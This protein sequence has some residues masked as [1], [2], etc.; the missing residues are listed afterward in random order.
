MLYCFFPQLF[1][2][3][4]S[5]SFFSTQVLAYSPAIQL[6]TL[7]SKSFLKKYKVTETQA[8]SDST[9][10]TFVILKLHKK[11][12]KNPDKNK[13]SKQ[14]KIESTPG[15]IFLRHFCYIYFILLNPVMLVFQDVTS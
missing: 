5:M 9:R 7:F 10:Q 2:K 15:I 1:F 6:G 11:K 3:V 13:H 14:S 8:Q 4:Q 12:K